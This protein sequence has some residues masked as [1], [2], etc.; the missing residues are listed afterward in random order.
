MAYIEGKVGTE[1]DAKLAQ[2]EIQ[3]S[4][5]PL[6]DRNRRKIAITS[7]LIVTTLWLSD[8]VVYGY[9]CNLTAKKVKD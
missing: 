1:D 8:S 7:D 4:G 3:E 5:T 2:L 6:A 9:I